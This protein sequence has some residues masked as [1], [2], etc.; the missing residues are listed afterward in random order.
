MKAQDYKERLLQLQK[1]L[2]ENPDKRKT[3]S[4]INISAEILKCNYKAMNEVKN[5]AQD[6][7]YSDEF[8]VTN[9]NPF[10]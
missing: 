9:D 5:N 6:R 7:R 1:F 8:E 3:Y 4:D 2:K 10:L